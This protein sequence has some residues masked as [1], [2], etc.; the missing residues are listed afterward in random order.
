MRHSHRAVSVNAKWPPIFLY[1]SK[2]KLSYCRL[3][4]TRL[5]KTFSLKLLM[6]SSP[7]MVKL[8]LHQGDCLDGMARF[9]RGSAMTYNV[10]ADA[11]WWELSA[12]MC[13]GLEKAR[14]FTLLGE[15][16]K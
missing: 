1:L 2:S 11:V 9:E 6:I 15:V 12:W 3:R 13:A 14:N 16:L 10:V 8:R 5:C 4:M 7:N